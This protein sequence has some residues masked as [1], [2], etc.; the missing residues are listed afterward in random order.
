MGNGCQMPGTPGSS[1]AVIGEVLALRD[2]VAKNI[3]V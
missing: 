2:I 3:E 1:Y